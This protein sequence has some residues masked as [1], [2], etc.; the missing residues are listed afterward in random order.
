MSRVDPATRRAALLRRLAT[1]P[2]RFDLFGALRRIEALHPD[3]PR[4]GEAAR[5]ADEPVR[6]AQE[7]SLTFAPAAVASFVDARPAARLTQRV[8]GFVG[9]NGPLPT[10]L[11][12]YTRERTLHHGDPTMQRFLDMLLHRFGLLFYRAWARAQPVVSLDRK[13]DSRVARHLG[14]LAGL[15]DTIHR[16]AD[17]L[18]HE[19]KL[20][21]MPRLARSVRDAEGLA[22]WI[23]TWFGVKASVEQNVGHWMALDVAE[24]SRLER[25]G[26]PALGRGVV[27]GRTIWD[28]QHKFRIVIGPLDFAAFLRFLPGATALMELRAMV[29]QYVGFEF[30]WDLRL[31]LAKVEVPRWQLGARAE[32][33]MLGRTSWVGMR[34]VQDAGDLLLNVENLGPRVGPPPG[35]SPGGPAP[36][37]TTWPLQGRGGSERSERG[38]TFTQ[39]QERSS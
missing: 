14:A 16:D 23:A 35:R 24:R 10:H 21:F 29:R 33:G 36:G 11:T 22:A 15:A 34:R 30:E 7:P 13:S 20:Y 12:E 4:L 18:G 39:L 17:L 28:V 26:Q 38:G 1:E 37:D 3:K 25:H 32:V 6:F 27:L 8:F 19:P 31:V 2:F 9:P 5:P